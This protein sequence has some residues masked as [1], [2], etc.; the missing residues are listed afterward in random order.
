MLLFFSK[1]YELVDILTGEVS[2]SFLH[3]VGSDLGEVFVTGTDSSF[4][5]FILQTVSSLIFDKFYLLFQF[6]E[7]RLEPD[8]K[9]I[10]SSFTLAHEVLIFFL[11][12]SFF[13]DSVAM[14]I[15][16]LIELSFIFL[17]A[18]F[19]AMM[20]CPNIHSLELNIIM[21]HMNV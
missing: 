7:E 20:R 8:S 14:L 6:F 19:L 15:M 16:V 13:Q 1:A 2:V 4:N 9:T 18:E 3:D 21:R 11:E 5:F 12:G 10:P 17:L